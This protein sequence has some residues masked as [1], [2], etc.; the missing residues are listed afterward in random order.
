MMSASFGTEIA[1]MRGAVGE[2]II[3]PQKE[4]DRQT[5]FQ[6][7]IYIYIYTRDSQWDIQ[8]KPGV[9]TVLTAN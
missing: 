6:L 3:G 2:I 9:L 1:S 5:A 8:T 4:C 7:Y